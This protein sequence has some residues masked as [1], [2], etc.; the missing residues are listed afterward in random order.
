MGLLSVSLIEA[1]AI[2]D[3][4]WHRSIGRD[5][6][7]TPAHMMVQA[8]GISAAVVCGYLVLMTTFGNSA[9]ARAV[10]VGVFG[11]RAPI[12]AFIAAWGGITMVVS[13]PFD[14]WWHAAYGLDVKIVSPPHAVLLGG[15]LSVE[16]GFLILTLAAMNRAGQSDSPLFKPFE[17]MFLYVAGMILVSQMYYAF[18]YINNAYLHGARPYKAIGIVALVVLLM[19]SQACSYKWA[20]ASVCAVYMA[21]MVASILILPLFPAQPKLGPVF[22]PV[23]HMVPTNFP[24][25]LIVPGL[26]LDLL[27]RRTRDWKLWLLAPFSAVVFITVLVAVEWPFADFLMSPWADNRFFAANDYGYSARGVDLLHVFQYSDTGEHFSAGIA[28]AM[29]FST[30]SAAIGIVLGRW[31]K[32]VRR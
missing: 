2:W 22:Y 19:V 10:S 28:K 26:V 4:S 13:A 32:G 21:V 24:M 18:F 7:W 14:N 9:A 31:M 12:G 16:V 5:S 17:R 29:L 1:G 20:A 3:L 15:V 27:W 6:F 11:L 23:T 30:F 8:G 25:L